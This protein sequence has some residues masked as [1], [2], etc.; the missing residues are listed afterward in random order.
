VIVIRSR[1]S[2]LFGKSM[3]RYGQQND[4]IQIDQAV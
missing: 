2:A 1:V 3:R 4:I